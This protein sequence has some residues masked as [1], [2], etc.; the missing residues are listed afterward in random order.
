MPDHNYNARQAARDLELRENLA[1]WLEAM[2]EAE[3]K[4]YLSA[5]VL[6]GAEPSYEVHG[7]LPIRDPGSRRVKPGA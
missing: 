6:D 3:K 5:G 1:N 4:K 7:R 2:P